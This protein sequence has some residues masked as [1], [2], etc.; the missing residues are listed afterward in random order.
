[1]TISKWEHQKHMNDWLAQRFDDKR[2]VFVVIDLLPCRV[3]ER[4]QEWLTR[5]IIDQTSRRFRNKINKIYFGKSARRFGK[6]L[7]MTIHLHE[8]PHRHFHCVIE[9][10]ENEWILRFKSNIDY[11][12]LNDGWMKPAKYIANTQSNIA[13]QIYNNRF[14]SDSILLF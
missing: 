2:S 4:Q 13:T 10:P 3:K 5:D 9:V 12:C 7:E 14:G 1:M 11:I 6:G 8:T